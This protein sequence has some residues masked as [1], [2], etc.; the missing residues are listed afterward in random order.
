MIG[1]EETNLYIIRGDDKYYDINFKDKDQNAIDIT[2]W[3]LY[4]TVKKNLGDSDEEAVIKKDIT[5]HTDPSNGKTRLHLTNADTEI[6]GGDYYYDIQVKRTSDDV[7][8][9]M[10]GKISIV[11]D[12]TR[13][14]E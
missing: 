11:H 4:F 3:K 8:T 14:K 12:R 1:H 2:G 13:R 5:T 6:N 7:F 9:V 10:I